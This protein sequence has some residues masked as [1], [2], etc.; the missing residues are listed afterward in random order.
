VISS[1]IPKKVF[2]AKVTQQSQA[3]RIVLSKKSFFQIS[4]LG[5]RIFGQSLGH[6]ACFLWALQE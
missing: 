2:F 6:F 4:A 3:L 1:E 5:Q